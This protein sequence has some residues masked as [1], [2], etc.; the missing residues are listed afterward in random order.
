LRATRAISV[1][2]T[3]PMLGMRLFVFRLGRAV[4]LPRLRPVDTPVPLWAAS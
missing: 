1:L 2:R 3:L 4:L